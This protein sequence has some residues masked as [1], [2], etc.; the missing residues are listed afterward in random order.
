MTTPAPALTHWIE[1]LHHAAWPFL[2]HRHLTELRRLETALTTTLATTTAT[3]PAERLLAVRT[4]LAPYTPSPHGDPANAATTAALAGFICG[5]HDLDL[6]DTIG[7]GHGR[8]ILRHATPALRTIWAARINS[9]ALVGIA[10]TERH[11]GS[12]LTEITTRLTP[13][14][15]GWRLTGEKCWVSRLKESAAFVVFAKDPNGRIQAAVVPAESD[16]VTR[17]PE[18]PSGLAGW[19]WGT[20]QLQDVKVPEENILTTPDGDGERIFRDH[21]TAFRPLVSAIALG[22][23]AGIHHH[24]LTTLQARTQTRLLPR[25]RDTTLTTLGHTHTSLHAALLATITATRLTAQ[26]S[27]HADLWARAIKVHGV[28]TAHRSVQELTPLIGASGFR[29]DSPTGKARADLGG[30]LYADGIHDALLRSVGRTLT[31]PN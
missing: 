7:P 19:A 25:L 28:E 18:T 3:T 26:H 4:A 12:R 11:G 29:A 13:H 31:D 14:A 27:T 10:A 22:T 30:L 17:F 8:M 21:F 6:R 20:L 1:P 24:V 2:T 16:G 9:G 5:W 23:A 15:D